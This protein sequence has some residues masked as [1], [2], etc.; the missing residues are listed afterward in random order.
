[1][2]FSNKK[3]H[4]DRYVQ[5]F[6]L[7]RGLSESSEENYT[8]RLKSYCN[9]LGKSPKELLDIAE[10]EQDNNIK[11]KDRKIKRYLLDYA[12]HL[13]INGRCESTIKGNLETI[14][15]FY[16]EYEI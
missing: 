7:A 11:M 6:Y 13:R 8:I 15:A 10:Q 4:N 16:H 3:I 14:K 1:M 2:K 12:D 5:D 9:F